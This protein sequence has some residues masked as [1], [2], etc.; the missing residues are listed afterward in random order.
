[1]DQIRNGIM[2]ADLTSD[3]IAAAPKQPQLNGG[4]ATS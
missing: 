4:S 2:V 1:M 3:T